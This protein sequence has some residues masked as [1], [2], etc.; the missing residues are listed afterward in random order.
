MQKLHRLV[1]N[2]LTETSLNFSQL[3]L[4]IKSIE[5][6]EILKEVS[7]HIEQRLVEELPEPPRFTIT[8]KEK[9]PE[10]E[11]EAIPIAVG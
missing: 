2:T 5:G 1:N 7:A 6:E 11:R 4:T 10:K 9:R 8:S 3:P